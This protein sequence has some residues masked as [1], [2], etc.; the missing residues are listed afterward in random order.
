[1][2]L[3]VVLP[4]RKFH[5]SALDGSHTDANRKCGFLCTRIISPELV[6]VTFHSSFALQSLCLCWSL[7]QFFSGETGVWRT[8]TSSTLII[9]CTRKPLRMSYTSAQTALK[10]TFIL[11]Y[12]HFDAR[13]LYCLYNIV[14]KINCKC[15]IIQLYL[16][17]VFTFSAEANVENGGR[18]CCLTQKIKKTIVF[19]CH[20]FCC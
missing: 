13:S 15:I 5:I 6:D 4:I 7:E 19:F 20:F 18:G 9:Q 11:R 2:A 10:V 1:M 3:Y 17:N 16:F 12:V 14:S 8:P